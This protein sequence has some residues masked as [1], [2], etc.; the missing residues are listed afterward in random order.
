MIP[1]MTF[2][3]AVLRWVDGDT[4]DVDVDLGFSIWSKQRIRLLGID[5]PERGQPMYIEAGQRAE[6][7]APAGTVV[8]LTT[9]GKDRYGR[10]LGVVTTGSVV[11]NEVL[12]AEGLA[13]PYM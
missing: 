6:A 4:V 10:Y 3:A 8:H 13:K 1:K 7:L 12:L 2:T 5:T 11:V 9:Q